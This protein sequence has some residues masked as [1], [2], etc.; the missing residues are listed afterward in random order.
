MSGEPALREGSLHVVLPVLVQSLRNTHEAQFHVH[1]KN[2]LDE[3]N[4]QLCV[5]DRNTNEC[6][7]AAAPFPFW[8]SEMEASL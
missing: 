4:L 2:F 1:V 7:T 6:V 8:K 3:Y 5:G